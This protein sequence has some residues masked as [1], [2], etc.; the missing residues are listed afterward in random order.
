MPS[1]DPPSKINLVRRNRALTQLLSLVLA[2]FSHL[3][4]GGKW[5]AVLH[6]PQCFAPIAPVGSLAVLSPLSVHRTKSGYTRLF[7]GDGD[8]I[9]SLCVVAVVRLCK[10]D[11]RATRQ[12]A[13]L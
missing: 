4:E 13:I 10:V 2:W 8:R 1:C 6:V 12:N 3:S 9:R 7:Y 5:R 11:L